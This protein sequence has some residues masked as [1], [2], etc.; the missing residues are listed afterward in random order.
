MFK[1]A[2]SFVFAAALM[3]SPVFAG[4]GGGG[5]KKDAT[6]RFSH[7]IP[8][9]PAVVVIGDPAAALKA[10]ILANTATLAEIIKAGG[11]LVRPGETKNLPVKAGNVALFGSTVNLANGDTA[12]AKTSIVPVAKGKKVTVLAST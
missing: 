12:F 9:A 7:D 8:G 5:A 1:F 2:L 3:A 10:K 4:G 6:I 11:V